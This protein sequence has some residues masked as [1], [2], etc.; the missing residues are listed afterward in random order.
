MACRRIVIFGWA[1]SVHVV[2]WVRGLSERGLQVRVISLGGEPIEG[3]D[4]VILPRR[5]RFSYF[6]HAS[7]A[8]ELAREFNP[9]LVHA[10]YAVGHGMWGMRSRLHPLVVS[11]W[12]TDVVEL[13][14]K[15]LKRW[16][17]RRILR[18][19]DHITA[20]SAFLA[21]RT[22]EVE[23]SVAHTLT[24][25]PFGVNIPDTTPPLPSY[26][27]RLAF[28]K[29]HWPRYAPELVLEALSLV[30]R[31]GHS[32]SVTLAG[33]G[34]MTAQLKARTTQLGLNDAVTFA[35]WVDPED[36]AGFLAAHHAIVMPS[37]REAFGVAVLEAAALGRPSI[38]TDIG[39]I[40]EVVR[41]G[42]TSLTVGV[43][44]VES[45][46]EAI[47]KL[48][49]D[50]EL[51]QQLGDNAYRFVQSHYTWDRSLDMMI[52]LYDR[53]VHAAR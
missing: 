30:K 35:G 19:A 20:T 12:G 8:A 18:H 28:I 21:K 25:I 42:E 52:D 29:H 32:V 36:M 10:H 40:P 15:P 1:H 6:R 2:R 17:V 24:T 5:G 9:D 47:I 11:V 53:L 41:S 44:D 50:R 14:G 4:T 13:T 45:L 7:C 22:S 37:R 16:L 34:P 31:E 39:G 49:T 46:A 26:P 27:L 51:L 23:P 43:D 33:E 38:T 48:A 3:I